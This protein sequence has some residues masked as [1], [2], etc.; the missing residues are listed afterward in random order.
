MINKMIAILK[1]Y[2]ADNNEI[3]LS[4]ETIENTDRIDKNAVIIQTQSN[5][6]IIARASVPT[7]SRKSYI[8][9]QDISN[10]K[11]SI[12]LKYKK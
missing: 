12:S 6:T 3:I 2:A 4:I 7:I 8:Y 9:L 5:K 1:K 11:K 10:P